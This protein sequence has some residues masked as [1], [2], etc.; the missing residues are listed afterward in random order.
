MMGLMDGN[1][2][3]AL[4]QLV[5]I[6]DSLHLEFE[7][8]S[9]Y[10]IKIRKLGQGKP[11]YDMKLKSQEYKYKLAIIY[12]ALFAWFFHDVRTTWAILATS[13]NEF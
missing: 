1:R 13:S 5:G 8:I 10:S 7:E 6:T 4:S 3:S 2:L 11:T 9:W 12:F